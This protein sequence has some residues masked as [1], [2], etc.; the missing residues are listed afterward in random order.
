LEQ[1]RFVYNQLKE[2]IENLN[3]RKARMENASRYEFGWGYSV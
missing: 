1:Y 2:E 3:T